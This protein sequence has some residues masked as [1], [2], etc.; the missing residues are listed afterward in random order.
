MRQLPAGSPGAYMLRTGPHGRLYVGDG[1]G[2]LY[3]YD[4]LMDRFQNLASNVMHGITWGGCVTPQYVVWTVTRDAAVYDWMNDKLVKTFSPIDTDTP[5]SQYG[6]NVIL[7]PDGKV[8][9]FMDVPKARI[10]ELDL[11]KMTNRSVTPASYAGIAAT[12]L[13][14]FFDDNTL[15][16][17]CAGATVAVQILSYPDYKLI[18][19]VPLPKQI[20]LGQYRGALLD[21]FLYLVPAHP[22]GGL[23]RL[24]VAHRKWEVLSSDWTNGDAA[25]LGVYQKSKV[26]GI[27]IRGTALCYDPS[28]HKT[29]TMDVGNLGVLDAHAM[30]VGPEAQII[31]GAPFIN[32]SFWTIDMRTGQGQD[33]G[34]AMPG[35]G[36]I[37]QIVWDAGRHRAVMSSYTAAAITEYDPAEGGAWPK[38]PR[39][40][41]SAES[42]GQMRPLDLKFDGHFFWMATDAS[43]GHLGGALS[44][45]NCD[46]NE[47]KVWN[48]LVHDQAV[49]GIVLDT[50][51]H[52]VYFSTTIYADSNSVPPTQ[53]T[54]EVAVFDM[55]KLQMDKRLP[56]P[57]GT[58]EASVI[59]L[60]DD[61]RVLLYGGKEYFAWDGEKERLDALGELAGEIDFATKDGNGTIW[62]TLGQ[63]I[64]RVSVRDR[65]QF[66][67]VI[68]MRGTFLQIVGD[69]MYWTVGT[70]VYTA[71]IEEL[72]K[73]E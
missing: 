19:E 54:A 52:R 60:L 16:S 46:T 11:S 55:I 17:V 31:V 10:V 56:L 9:L 62:A 53:K 2:D 4:P 29:T 14:R 26:A 3:R 49:N 22:L 42:Q 61:R 34:R 36:Q 45:I 71:K 66:D 8:L 67:P 35:A 7:A 73:P 65:I 57:Q 6:H 43:Y 18:A 64:G 38:N 69:V 27:T 63:H 50:K 39:L 41:A 24:D 23:V 32:A 13:A 37:N 48:N 5:H 28:T 40:V 72:E 58:P 68:P 59:C 44:R 20:Q 30:A 15:V 21:G 12:L 51:K 1:K 25:Y 70:A 33:R 47:I